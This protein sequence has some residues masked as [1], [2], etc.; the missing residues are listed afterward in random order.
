M[1]L[2]MMPPLSLCA[3]M[4][5]PR[6]PPCLHTMLLLCPVCPNI[7]LHCP[8]CL[9]VMLPCYPLHPLRPLHARFICPNIL[10]LYTCDMCVLWAQPSMHAT[11]IVVHPQFLHVTSSSSLVLVPF[12][13]AIVNFVYCVPLAYASLLFS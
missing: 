7:M 10:A 11:D 9:H 12:R 1:C 4:L 6:C 8:L 13:D 3:L 2:Y 5:C